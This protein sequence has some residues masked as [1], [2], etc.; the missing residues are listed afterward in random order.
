MAAAGTSLE[1]WRALLEAKIPD[2]LLHLKLSPTFW[3]VIVKH[4]AIQEDEAENIQVGLTSPICF[5]V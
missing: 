3:T 1:K 5:W 2:L 4:E